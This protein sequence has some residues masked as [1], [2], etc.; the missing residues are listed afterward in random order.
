LAYYRRYKERLQ[1]K[2]KEIEANIQ[3]VNWKIDYYQKAAEAGTEAIHEG[4]P[5]LYEIYYKK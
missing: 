4:E 1:L 2:I 3:K 5:G